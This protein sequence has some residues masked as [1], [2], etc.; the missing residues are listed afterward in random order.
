M[1]GFNTRRT[2]LKLS[3]NQISKQV[4]VTSANGGKSHAIKACLALPSI[5]I[6]TSVRENVSWS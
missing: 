1:T 6:E 3:T 5:V 4:P 2:L